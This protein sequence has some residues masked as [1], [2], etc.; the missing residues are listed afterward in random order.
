VKRNSLLVVFLAMVATQAGC[1]PFG[2]AKRGLAEIQG[3]QG[4]VFSLSEDDTAFYANMSG[5]RIGGVTNTIAPLCEP[6]MQQAV[7]KALGYFSEEASLG[8]SGSG[9]ECTIAVDITF[10]AEPGGVVALIGKGALLIG[11][12]A[13]LDADS[14]QVADLIV[15][16]SSEAV[17]TTSDEMAE[18][19]A[20]TLIEYIGSAGGGADQPP[21]PDEVPEG[22][23]NEG[24]EAGMEC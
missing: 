8:M 19:F 9:G 4:K 2:L 13:I 3:A 11:R 5:I 14:Q 1:S 6:E 18:E 17:R 23:S 20:K 15:M 21:N 12:V 16:V 24:T 10:N 7:E 22:Q